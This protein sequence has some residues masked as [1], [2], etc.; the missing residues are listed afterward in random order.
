MWWVYDG[1]CHCCMTERVIA[2]HL[3]DIMQ[4]EFVGWEQ[5]LTARSCKRDCTN[6][7]VTSK[8]AELSQWPSAFCLEKNSLHSP[9]CCSSKVF[10]VHPVR[11]VQRWCY[12]EKYWKR[13]GFGENCDGKI[14]VNYW[15][16]REDHLLV[17]S[18]VSRV[19]ASLLKPNPVVNIHKQ[20][21][22]V[23]LVS[24]SVIF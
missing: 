8:W 4:T 7:S 15:H 11:A 21:W 16:A 1:R 14:T 12:W 20:T 3:K 6:F 2:Y 5:M 9:F 10:F 24:M 13:W 17:I 22:T 23:I 18:N 19:V